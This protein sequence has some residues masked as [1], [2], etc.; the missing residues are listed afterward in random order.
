[1]KWVGE[2]QENGEVKPSWIDEISKDLMQI[3]HLVG[4][5][6][7]KIDFPKW[8][9]CISYF[10][11]IKTVVTCRKH[12]SELGGSL[13]WVDLDDPRENWWKQLVRFSKMVKSQ[14]WK[15]QNAK[16]VIFHLRNLASILNC[17]KKLTESWEVILN[18]SFDRKK[19]E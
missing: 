2:I 16:I 15:N 8:N 12:A 4:F 6:M 14:V 17:R 3:L 18:K 9:I 7:G 1:M 11:A 5:K 13:K 19:G 10:L